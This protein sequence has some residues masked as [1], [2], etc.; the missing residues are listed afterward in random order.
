MPL[1]TR[2]IAGRMG[3]AI[4]CAALTLEGCGTAFPPAPPRATS[5]PPQTNAQTSVITIPIDVRLRNV[6]QALNRPGN[7][8]ILDSGWRA[9]Q[10]ASNDGYA[11]VR[12][13][14]A[15]YLSHWSGGAIW[16][17]ATYLGATSL[18]TLGA[19]LGASRL[20]RRR[21]AIRPSSR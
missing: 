5:F 15:T 3:A 14:I 7:S 6:R 19:V 17:V 20:T 11:D 1:T 21:A 13:I 10:T 2:A 16:Y 9:V 18:I 4:L 12:S 8:T